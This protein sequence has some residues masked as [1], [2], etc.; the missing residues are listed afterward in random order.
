MFAEMNRAVRQG[1]VLVR[2]ENLLKEFRQYVYVNGKIEHAASLMTS[3]DSSKGKAHGDR[4][5]AFGVA[6]QML[7]DRPTFTPRVPTDTT[8]VNKKPPPGT[9]AAR[10]AGY[11]EQDKRSRNDR[12]G[13]YGSI[14]SGE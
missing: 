11:R 1:E 3:D 5:I 10:M 14:L 12:D 7:Q 4:V 8:S 2:D 13:W 9:M 6:L